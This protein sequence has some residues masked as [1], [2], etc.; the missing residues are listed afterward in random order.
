MQ[1]Q[2]ISQVKSDEISR[3]KNWA[4]P[5][6]TELFT[7]QY[8]FACFAGNVLLTSDYSAGDILFKTWVGYKQNN[9]TTIRQSIS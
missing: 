7:S 2:T 1:I 4:T 5:K 3:L 8:S 9:D 6:L